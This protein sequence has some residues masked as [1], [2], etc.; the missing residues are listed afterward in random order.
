MSEM[1]L[2][3]GLSNTNTLLNRP[4]KQFFWHVEMIDT[5]INF[6]SKANRNSK[7]AYFS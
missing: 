7:K 5:I 2:L 3:N 1:C 4:A 6:H